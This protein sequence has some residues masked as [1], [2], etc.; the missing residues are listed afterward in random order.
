MFD[1]LKLP[2]WLGWSAFGVAGLYFLAKVGLTVAWLLKVQGTDRYEPAIGLLDIGLGILMVI[3]GAGLQRDGEFKRLVG[4]LP[5]EILKN[6]R[7]ITQGFQKLG[8]QGTEQH[9]ES[10]KKFE[11]L[12]NT[13]DKGLNT[14]GV[15]IS[16][17]KD[18]TLEGFD[19]NHAL[20]RQLEEDTKQQTTE[21][22]QGQV[23]LASKMDKSTLDLK[24]YVGFVEVSTEAIQSDLSIIRAN[25]DEI[26]AA[27]KVK[28]EGWDDI[29]RQLA[30]DIITLAVKLGDR[31]TYTT[32][33]DHLPQLDAMMEQYWD[34]R[35]RSIAILDVVLDDITDEYKGIY[36]E[37][38]VAIINLSRIE[39]KEKHAPS[40]RVEQ[41]RDTAFRLGERHMALVR[42]AGELTVEVKRR[43]KR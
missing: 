28:P 14:V 18:I 20:I 2:R 8:K 33:V 6:R 41:W 29:Q 34:L 25:T 5:Q 27:V 21:L 35:D 42:K 40:E 23:E 11:D 1:N 30:D 10:T 24:G 32:E 36:S 15:E 13:V 9:Q 22:L 38:K 37:L 7:I 12:G 39:K 16:N 19:G 43:L 4:S 17:L 26:L 31:F 3:A